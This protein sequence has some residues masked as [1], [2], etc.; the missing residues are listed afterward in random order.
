MDVCFELLD[1]L[2]KRAEL[3]DYWNRYIGLSEADKFNPT[4]KITWEQVGD[5]A[6]KKYFGPDHG[7]E[8]FNKHGGMIWP[9]KVEEA[10]WRYFTDAR[11]PIYLECLV[12]LKKKIKKIA[13]GIG[14]KLNWDQYTP[15]VEWFPCT[16]HLVNDSKL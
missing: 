11:V 13:D 4:E 15:L 2:G 5:K 3:N 6:L 1:R 9:K 12:D 14:I 16:P 8:W 7:L 10:Y